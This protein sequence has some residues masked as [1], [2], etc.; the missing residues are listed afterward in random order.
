A[1][2]WSPTE[3][4]DGPITMSLDTAT[5]QWRYVAHGT[6]GVDHHF[7]AAGQLVK[8]V[9]VHDDLARPASPE[10]GYDLVTGR[11]RTLKDPVTAH[12]ITLVYGSDPY[13]PGYACPAESAA[14]VGALCRIQ[15]WNGTTTD[16]FYVADQLARIAD[17]GGAA[18]DLS[19]AGGRLV[20]IRDALAADAVAWSQRSDDATVRT[21]IAYDGA[22]RVQSVT[23]PAPTAGAARPARSYTYSSTLPGTT[24]VAVA[25]LPSPPAGVAR[26]VNYDAAG[27]VRTDTDA[28]GQT[29]MTTFDEEDLVV[30]R[31]DGAG[32]KATY[33]YDHARRPVESWGPAP[34]GCF[35]ASAPP[36]FSGE[37]PNG[38]CADPAVP[39]SRT[40]YDEGLVGL[41]AAYFDNPE[42]SGSPRAHA[43]G[44]GDP[45]G[46]LYH[47][48]GS[49]APAG[50]GTDAWSA[51]FSGE[52]HLPT[53]GTYGFSAYSDTGVRIYVDERLVGDYWSLPGFTPNATVTA[54]AGWHRLRV[55]Y[56]GAGGAAELQLLWSGPGGSGGVPGD[57]LR[58]GYGLPTSTT[59]AGGNRTVT[60]YARPEYGLATAT[61]VDPGGLNLRSTTTYE[62][63]GAGYLRR[64]WRAL[65][66]A[67]NTEGNDNKVTYEYYR[68]LDDPAPAN[69]CNGI[70]VV[71]MLKRSTDATPA[72]GPDTAVKRE[73]VYDASHRVVGQRVVGDPRW[74]CVTY[75][76]RGRVAST[77]DAAAKTAT[78]EHAGLDHL[79]TFVDSAGTTRLTG[80]S[81]DLLGR[82]RTYVDEQGTTTRRS[83]TLL[84]GPESTWRSFM[85]GGEAL[86]ST[87]AYD[88]AG[89]P[90]SFTDHSSGTARTTLYGYDAVGRPSITTG[91]NAVVATTGYNPDTGALASVAHA[92]AGAG[93]ADWTVTRYP[94]G[95]VRTET[96]SGRTRTHGYDR[97]GRLT[98]VA[99]TTAAGTLTRNYAYDANT[100]RCSA[101]GP[102]CDGTWVYDSAD[103]LTSSPFASAHVYDGHGNLTSATLRPGAT[104]ATAQVI[105]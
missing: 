43:T 12:V 8:A 40:A 10:Y 23:L 42:L 67:N 71:G 81:A 69:E 28:N 103:R 18:T 88:S 70:A 100:N 26:R 50:I 90:Q 101:S 22:G 84:G 80:G 39:V 34:A 9:A 37:V 91:P 83:Y 27:R 16:L 20:S 4:G 76:T 55:D 73:V 52:V 36:G 68:A 99:E 104:A 35:G 94:S 49:G 19:Y 85:G 2:A 62:A 58:P 14:P 46:A 86:L 87:S 17:P 59:D 53:T 47:N 32:L 41:A 44:V 15:Y 63:P 65:P 25:G 82:P 21:A 45:S 105:T 89:R 72:T 31:T 95:N 66:K 3:P 5:G 96:A 51:R 56:H 11:L 79:T 48:W 98:T 13:S 57:K 97:A 33:V 78:T 77:T 38:S 1:L 29:T 61:V 74:S 93:L 92:R 54:T 7:N 64:T 6:D 102:T 60:E 30:S 75:D 24:D